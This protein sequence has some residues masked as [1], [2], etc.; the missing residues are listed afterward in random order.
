[1]IRQR[2]FFTAGNILEDMVTSA[3]TILLF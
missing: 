2:V 1:M 3:E